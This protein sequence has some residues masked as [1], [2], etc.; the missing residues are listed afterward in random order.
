VAELTLKGRRFTLTV[1][2]PW[3]FVTQRGAGPFEVTV[4]GASSTA[5]FLRLANAF[6]FDGE[7]WTYV[8]ATPRH[9]AS[10][11]ADLLHQGKLHVN[12]IRVSEDVQHSDP[13]SFGW[14]QY[15]GGGH[16]LTATLG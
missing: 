5:V 7:E 12:V 13:E 1:S 4:K 2:D 6:T 8:S 3:E 14:K 16:M 9:K 10:Q 11:P 15:R